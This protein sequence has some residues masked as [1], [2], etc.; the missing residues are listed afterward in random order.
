MPK[1][2]ITIDRF[3][4]GIDSASDARDLKQGYVADAVNVMVDEVGIIRTMGA[5]ENH[6]AQGDT[7]QPAVTI[8]A[9]RGLYAF[10]HDRLEGEQAATTDGVPSGAAAAETSN[11]TFSLMLYSK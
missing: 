9:G 5:T 10:S 7:N 1:Q 8:A 6:Y 3:E 11:D 4:K 2:Q